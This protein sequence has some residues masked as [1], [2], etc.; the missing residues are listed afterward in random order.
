MA[1]GLAPYRLRRAATQDAAIVAGHR[2]AMF[3]DMGVLAQTDTPRLEASSRR[4][5]AQALADGQYYGWLA[6]IDGAVAAGVGVVLRP[7]L[8]R[9]GCLDGGRD[10]YV[11][12]VYTEPAH[13][14]RGL[15]RAL[16]QAVLQWCHA[17]GITR[18]ALHASDEGR[19]L[20]ESL[21]FAPTNEMIRGPKE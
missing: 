7:L 8:P 14:R 15:A 9:P 10:A 11:L 1:P 17:A 4:H 5:L 12:N 18:V 6:E 21:G 20:Y 13:R 16:M 3:R 19:P 2:V